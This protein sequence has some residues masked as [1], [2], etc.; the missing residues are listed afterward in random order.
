MHEALHRRAYCPRGSAEVFRIFSRS[1]WKLWTKSLS[2]ATP[3]ATKRGRFS[4]PPYPTARRALKIRRLA[5]DDGWWVT[6]FSGSYG[7]LANT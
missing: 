7:R 5:S 1:A 3:L 2:A 6:G 4:G